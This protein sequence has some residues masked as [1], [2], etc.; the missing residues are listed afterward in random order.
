MDLDLK[1]EYQPVIRLCLSTVISYQYSIMYPPASL[2]N[3][4]T[5]T[6]KHMSCKDQQSAISQHLARQTSHE[7]AAKTTL[8]AAMP[9]PN[10]S[11]PNSRDACCLGSI[12]PR[13]E[14]VSVPPV[15]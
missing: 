8:C 9:K 2:R 7:H 5:I 10:S 14:C 13:L 3:M 6:S 4:T 15:R 12:F 11:P 1:S